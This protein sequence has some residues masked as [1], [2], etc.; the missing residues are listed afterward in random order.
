MMS[1]VISS[2]V[3]TLQQAMK[4]IEAEDSQDILCMRSVA[5]E[6]AKTSDIRF[7]KR[8]IQRGKETAI[9][10]RSK[11]ESWVMKLHP[12]LLFRETRLPFLV[13]EAQL[14][15]ASPVT[16]Y[17]VLKHFEYLLV[18]V[19]FFHIQHTVK[20]GKKSV[21]SLNNWI[22][23][24]IHE[25][26]SCDSSLADITRLYVTLEHDPWQAML[27][28]LVGLMV[29]ILDQLPNAYDDMLYCEDICHPYLKIDS[30]L[31]S[32][33]EKAYD[34]MHQHLESFIAQVLYGSP[35]KTKCR[36]LVSAQAVREL[37]LG[38]SHKTTT[39]PV[40]LVEAFDLVKKEAKS[41]L[42]AHA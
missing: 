24:N 6:R 36:Y 2:P 23:L 31:E 26:L 19:L 8:P 1:Q 28:F 40:E 18:G 13:V 5:V 35:Q 38:I 33:D 25:S 34:Y 32:W 21:D 16:T 41:W 10:L 27:N 29:E 22:H 15:L 42:V 39:V 4:L 30:I 14:R 3:K 7:K 37:V 12:M 20:K 9:Q 17:D 11:I